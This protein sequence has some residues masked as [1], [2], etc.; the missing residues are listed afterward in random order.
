[1]S[2]PPQTRIMRSSPFTIKMSEDPFC[3]KQVSTIDL[4]ARPLDPAPAPRAQVSTGTGSQPVSSGPDD[5][6][7]K[8]CARASR[9]PPSHG[10]G[11]CSLTSNTTCTSAVGAPSAHQRLAPPN[12][13]SFGQKAAE[14]DALGARSCAPTSP[15]CAARPRSESADPAQRLPRW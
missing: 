6:R 1:M 2:F 14:L 11:F 10:C 4:A 9:C 13:C 12:S 8:P 7:L 3:C 15:R 5:P